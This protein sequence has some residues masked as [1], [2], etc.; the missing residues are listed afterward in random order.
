LS[1]QQT[2]RE[3]SG[4]VFGARKPRRRDHPT[5]PDRRRLGDGG[6]RLARQPPWRR[7]AQAGGPSHWRPNVTDQAE[8]YPSLGP[9]R[10]E[11]QTAGSTSWS[12]PPPHTVGT[13]TGPFWRV[14]RIAEGERRTRFDYVGPPRR[15]APAFRIPLRRRE[16]SFAGPGGPSQRS[17][18]WTG[19][20]ARA[21]DWPG[22]GLWAGR[23]AFGVRADHT[24][25]AALEF[26]P[27]AASMVAPA[28][29]R[30]P[31]SNTR[32]RAHPARAS[33]TGRTPR[34]T[35]ARSRMPVRFLASPRNPSRDPRA[36]AHATCRGRGVAV[37]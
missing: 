5:P 36:P 9:G 7:F 29:R 32:E 14:A 19:G 1:N 27:H 17:S 13:R 4:L 12:M 21:R 3:K 20:S 8:R 23:G 34:P 18:R 25:A 31:A 15:L 28:D 35:P 11:S 30:R 2:E 6:R 37:A 33:C 22:R 16:A 24:K 10:R 26:A